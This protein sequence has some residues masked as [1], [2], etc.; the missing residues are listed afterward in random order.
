MI[1]MQRHMISRKYQRGL[2]FVSVVLVGVI[3]V[4]V[5]AVVAQSLPIF[6]EEMAIKKGVKKSAGEIT[7]KDARDS[8]DRTANIDNINAISGK[9]L[10]I[11]N[12]GDGKIM[13]EY[14][15]EREIKLF[16]P[17]Y[18]IYRFSGSSTTQ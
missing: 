15:Y 14:S 17:A 10:K 8:F 18:L 1:V 11:V 3:L 6:V 4:A 9:D 13:V 2:S 16:G 5:G 12:A 7:A